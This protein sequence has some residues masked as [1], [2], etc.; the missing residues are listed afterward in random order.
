MSV[1]AN[2]LEQIVSQKQCLV[3]SGPKLIGEN[4]K[5]FNSKD[6]DNIHPEAPN[7]KYAESLRKI[8]QVASHIF[9]LDPNLNA[10]LMDKS[11]PYTPLF[12]YMLLLANYN[13]VEKF[14]HSIQDLDKKQLAKIL[15]LAE[16]IL[17]IFAKK[18]KEPILAAIAF[19]YHND[20]LNLQELKGARVKTSA[21]TLDAAHAH[22]FGITQS[23]LLA[24]ERAS[25]LPN[26]NTLLISKQEHRNINDPLMP[27]IRLLLEIPSI[28]QEIIY[29]LEKIVSEK[30]GEKFQVLPTGIQFAINVS[31]L[32]DEEL[33]RELQL[34][35]E[36]FE[37]IYQQIANLFVNS[38]KPDAYGM[39]N[40]RIDTYARVNQFCKELMNEPLNNK[41]KIEI[42]HLQKLLQNFRRLLQPMNS[43]RA[44]KGEQTLFMR[45]FACTLTIYKELSNNKENLNKEKALWHL[46]LAPRIISTGN[47]LSTLN[48]YKIAEGGVNKNW[49][50]I[51]RS[52]ISQLKGRSEKVI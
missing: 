1:E 6:L 35:Q 30:N 41:A 47:G 48:L 46:I 36:R 40:L 4:F 43:R 34:L 38:Q 33:A 19:N 24:A 21:Q 3:I 28:R 15:F 20:P 42:E 17:H 23:E 27:L 32:A 18:A 5:S 29:G 37:N 25:Y 52:I 26:I 51:K 14:I 2:N 22:I 7:E 39:P 11:K 16:E 10:Y 49:K 45:N 13:S 31:T 44:S 8:G 9:H 12:D 50:R